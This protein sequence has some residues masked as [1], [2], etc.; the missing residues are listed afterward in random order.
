MP[1]FESSPADK[2][3][4]KSGAKKVGK[5]AKAWEGSAPDR[6]MDAKAIKKMRKGKK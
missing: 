2:K 3:A 4:D 6:K 5:S 1:K